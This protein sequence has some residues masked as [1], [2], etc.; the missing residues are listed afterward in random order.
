MAQTAASQP[1]PSVPGS[2]QPVTPAGALSL[3]DTAGS[4]S[5][6]VPP[7]GAPV[8]APAPAVSTVSGRWFCRDVNAASPRPASRNASQPHI[9]SSPRAPS[10]PV[11][12]LNQPAAHTAI[13][14]EIP[15]NE[16]GE[17]SRLVARAASQPRA[18]RA[19]PA[20]EISTRGCPG[21]RAVVV[22]PLPGAGVSDELTACRA[23]QSG[24]DL[25]S[26]HENV[27]NC[28]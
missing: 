12:P 20:A 14:T 25:A 4:T 10:S 5:Q 11:P 22:A 19:S 24:E 3:H 26:L 9:A 15:D 27:T 1:N 21:R 2:S 28:N 17:I 13:S 8:P 23:L 18:R 6:S 16:P 7:S